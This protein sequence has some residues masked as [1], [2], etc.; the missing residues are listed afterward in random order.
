MPSLDKKHISS[1]ALRID[2]YYRIAK[3]TTLEEVYKI[4]EEIKERF[5]DLPKKT[6][7][8]LN[9]SKLKAICSKTSISR[10]FISKKETSFCLK[11]THPFNSLEDL[12]SSVSGF[13]HEEFV[14]YRYENKPAQGFFVFLKTK[15]QIPHMN[16]LFSFVNLFNSITN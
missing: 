4:E 11:T 8:L 5:G 13:S 6:I 9:I 10:I 7:T 3:T 16:V 12:F 2:Y 14:E 15:N 1:Q